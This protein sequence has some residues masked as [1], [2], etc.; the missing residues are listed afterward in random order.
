MYKKNSK[1]S[2][3]K[4]KKILAIYLT[5][6][7]IASGFSIISMN[8]NSETGAPPPGSGNSEGGGPYYSTGD[9]AI[10]NGDDIIRI[11]QTI[12]LK[13][14]LIIE[15]GGKLTFKNVTLIMDCSYDGE[16]RIEVNDGGSFYIQENP[17]PGDLD[18]FCGDE[19]GQ[20]RFYENTGNSQNPSFPQRQNIQ[21]DGGSNINIGDRANIDLADLDDDGDYDLFVGDGDNQGSSILFY[22][23]TGTVSEPIWTN[24]G[25]VQDNTGSNIGVGYTAAPCF[26]DLDDDGDLDLVIGS[27]ENQLNYYENTGTPSIPEWTSRGRLKDDGGSD[28]DVGRANKLDFADYWDDDGDLD[29]AVGEEG[30]GINFYRN[31]GDKGSAIWKL[32]DEELYNHGGRSAPEFADLNDDGLLDLIIGESEGSLNYHENKGTKALP[33]YSTNEANYLGIDS[34]DRSQPRF[35]DIDKDWKESSPSIITANN[36]EYEFKFLVNEGATFVMKNSELSECGYESGE[37]GRAGLIIK[38]NNTLIENSSFYNNYKGIYLNSSHYS[39]IINNNIYSNTDGIY[40]WTS[41]NNQVINNNVSYNR[42]G[43]YLVS[44]SKNQILNNSISNNKYGIN[45]FSSINNNQITNNSV[46]NNEHGVY[47]VFSTNNQIINNSVSNNIWG[48]MF[49]ESNNNQFINSTIFDSSAHDIR[50]ESKSHITVINTTFDRDKVRFDDEDSELI[51]KWYLSINVIDNN[52]FGVENANIQIK[53]QFSDEKHN[54]TTNKDGWKK[55]IEIEEYREKNAGRTE[56][57][58]FNFTVS[59]RTTSVNKEISFSPPD[60]HN[61][62]LTFKLPIVGEQFGFSTSN[63]GDINNDGYDDIIVGA[64]YSDWNGY[65]SG[66]AYVYYGYSNFDSSNLN[67][68]DAN[69]TIVGEEGSLFG[70]S[71]SGDGDVNNDTFDDVIV[72]APEATIEGGMG[73]TYVFYGGDSINKTV[74]AIESNVR[75]FG[76]NTDSGFGKN[77]ASVGDVNGDGFDDFII[78]EF[79]MDKAQLVYG[80]K[81]LADDIIFYANLWDDDPDEIVDFTNITWDDLQTGDTW[82]IDGDDDGWDTSPTGIYGGS[83]TAVRYNPSKEE[84]MHEVNHSL[85]NVS[86]LQIEIGG[87]KDEGNRASGAY[88]IEIEITQGMYDT[89]ELATLKFDWTLFSNRYENEEMLWLKARFGNSTGM[90]YLGSNLDDNEDSDNDIF[91]FV[92]PGTNQRHTRKG[93]FEEDISYL[94]TEPGN[95]YLELGGKN[96]AWSQPD[97]Y[98]IVGYDNISLSLLKYGSPRSNLTGDNI[99]DNFGFSVSSAGDV[100]NDTF[101]DFII[102]APDFED[103]G[104]LY[105][106]YGNNNMSKNIDANL[107]I[108]GEL[109]SHF[110]Y[111]VSSAGDINNDGFDDIIVG[112][113]G[114]GKS[115]VYYGYEGGIDYGVVSLD[116]T[117]EFGTGSADNV[118][119]GSGEIKLGISG[120]IVP[121]GFFDDGWEY[122]TFTGDAERHDTSDPNG[123]I[124]EAIG[125]WKVGPISGGPTAGFGSDMD[126]I[127]GNDERDSDGKLRSDT[128]AI[129]NDV[130]YLH[131]WYHWKVDDYDLYGGNTDGCHLRIF[132]ATNDDE[133]LIIAQHETTDVRQ[134]WE[135]EEELITDVSTLHGY[136]VYIELELRCDNSNRDKGLAQIDDI[137]SCDSEGNPQDPNLFGN[138]TSLITDTEGDIIG[139][140]PSWDASLNDGNI[141]I[142]FRA[143]SSV[144]WDDAKIANNNELLSFN[145]PGNETQFNAFFSTPDNSTT[146]ILRK[147]SY[148]YFGNRLATIIEGNPDDKF[149]YSVS[150]AGDLNNDKIDDII[151]GA[152][153]N[154]E[155]GMDAGAAYTFYGNENLENEIDANRAFGMYYGE[156]END[157]F[158]HSVSYTGNNNDLTYKQAVV[159]APDFENE[160]GWVYL[161]GIKTIDVGVMAIDTP[162]RDELLWLGNEIDIIATIANFGTTLQN[163]IEVHL[164][165][166][167]IEDSGNNHAQIINIAVLNVGQFKQRTFKWT[168]P[169][170]YE[171]ENNNYLISVYTYLAS[172]MLEENNEKVVPT[173]ARGHKVMLECE[174]SYK[175]VRASESIDYIIK[176]TNTGNLGDDTIDLSAIIPIDWSSGFFYESNEIT[177]IDLVEGEY[178]EIKFSV[179]TIEEAQHG[180]EYTIDVSGLSKNG[181]TFNTIE[182]TTRIKQ[183]DLEPVDL[184]FFRLDGV[185]IGIDK[186]AIADQDTTINATIKNNGDTYAT[187][188]TVT[189]YHSG[190]SPENIIGT[191]IVEII[192]NGTAEE[193][194]AEINWNTTI[195]DYTVFVEVDSND[196]FLESNEANND[197]SELLSVYSTIPS[198][199]YIRWIK[200]QYK[201]SNAVVNGL[202]AIKNMNSGEMQTN[203]TNDIGKTQFIFADYS[204]GDHLQIVVTNPEI[205]N[206]N[207][208]EGTFFAIEN[209]YAYSVDSSDLDS[210]FVKLQLEKNG[211]LVKTILDE[212]IIGRDSYA[213]F[214]V[215]IKVPSYYAEGEEEVTIGL[216][217][218][219]EN[220]ETILKGDELFSQ[221]D[222]YKLEVDETEWREIDLFVYPPENPQK[223]EYDANIKFSA[224]PDSIPLPGWY[225]DE[226]SPYSLTLSTKLSMYN[227]SMEIIDGI[228]E[229]TVDPGEST[230][231]SID[232]KNR[233][234]VWDVVSLAFNGENINWVSLSKSNLTLNP[235]NSE[236]IY[237]T[238]DVPEDAKDTEKSVI[239]LWAISKDGTRSEQIIL[240]TNVYEKKHNVE[241][242][243]EY[244]ESDGI[245]TDYFLKIINTGDLNEKVFLEAVTTKNWEIEFNNTFIQLEVG[246]TAYVQ[247]TLTRLEEE[248]GSADDAY[249]LANYGDGNISKLI[250]NK[251]PNARIVLKYN[252]PV[253]NQITVKSTVTTDGTFS[254]D[255][256]KSE[257]KYTWDFGDGTIKEGQPTHMYE[258]ADNYFITLTVEDI[259]GLK[260]IAVR[261]VIVVNYY[262]PTINVIWTQDESVNLE[263]EEIIII[264]TNETLV[265]DASGSYDE[266]GFIE[267]YSWN[268]GNEIIRE[269][270]IIYWNYTN[271]GNYTITL[272]LE[273][274]FGKKKELPIYIDVRQKP[275][276]KVIPPPTEKEDVDETIIILMLIIV[277]ILA[278]L[279]VIA[280][281]RVKKVSSE[282][283]EVNINAVPP[284]QPI[285]KPPS[286]PVTPFLEPQREKTDSTGIGIE[287]ELEKG[288]EPQK[289]FFTSRETQ[290]EI[291][292]TSEPLMEEKE[293]HEIP[294]TKEG[295]IPG[296]QPFEEVPIEEKP[297]METEEIPTFKAL[298]VEEKPVVEE[299]EIWK[300][301]SEEKWT[302]PKP[303]F[304][305]KEE[306][307]PIFETKKVEEK[308]MFEEWK[309]EEKPETEE[310]LKEPGIKEEIKEEEKGTEE[311]VQKKEKKKAFDEDFWS[312][313]EKDTDF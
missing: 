247:T 245:R 241:S 166:T 208:P 114:V 80:N 13:G 224:L 94:I 130:D 92:P 254:D 58:P 65:N 95:Y 285:I 48:I 32:E 36:T 164:E 274:N 71:V 33:D 29:M 106:Y 51:V 8:V 195:G 271:P 221:N 124:D 119:I 63:A 24:Q 86:E 137:Y 173:K 159:G 237:I 23:N 66:A 83:E 47:L 242:N 272:I 202:V 168:V 299:K 28:I 298:P 141:E 235:S 126:T 186:H 219:P 209:I 122:W 165:I 88:G 37:D 283:K 228:D 96:T 102:G 105:V 152:P 226:Y 55:W 217:D 214:D 116:S 111:S 125:D 100:N 34:G 115:L 179:Q 38:A 167:C 215:F 212:A 76:R 73:G 64:P 54:L 280:L 284:S 253:P 72:G 44:S 251:P 305:E 231:F 243:L 45:V 309:V 67:P 218:I 240:K 151:I 101:N 60:N 7:M 300:P 89:M 244:T 276:D 149:G 197:Y 10:E 176:I 313:W 211:V 162:L 257:L 282:I 301:S 234:N 185:E 6:L 184:R 290:E 216:E 153:Y 170:G 117:Q 267:K 292:Q 4:L 138:Y 296:V 15:N 53:D 14:N 291:A 177:E 49:Y 93:T 225:L 175:S 148:Q 52:G 155:K 157:H 103:N 308:P 16:Y 286:E 281:I 17:Q 46:S 255:E 295:S 196:A 128:F 307:K 260:D 269:G 133:L 187:F 12:Y 204:E 109:N 279:I 287:E 3:R 118:S 312:D 123:M 288:F 18:L 248:W 75:F 246:Q 169:D 233:G 178:K 268:L 142:K 289:D 85:S 79:N 81:K 277:I 78:G 25:R 189:F 30:G 1:K 201:D 227:I 121:N 192:Y 163:N 156:N 74:Y 43:I 264:E 135:D 304:E 203:V 144:S 273:D 154:D 232:V 259:E 293:Q 5:G 132:D 193:A 9:W 99:G 303:L 91:Y 222:I 229:K 112:A 182:I 172:D 50:F 40:L 160:K 90:T 129:P 120:T 56:Y 27:W 107:T 181:I 136:T 310:I 158:G 262:S 220:W 210:D 97:E 84:S 188:V 62:V 171:N 57:S 258:L 252:N 2:N 70:W 140:I 265:L 278:I 207:I 61:Q 143:N 223:G 134:D 261:E 19:G 110:G 104:K 206:E 147:I 145:T 108:T 199:P 250:L 263:D 230:T 174:E 194:Y 42:N 238:I 180:Y 302:P 306:V 127:S 275:G 249:V 256:E 213:K 21:D 198:N 26:A 205:T 59:R 20:I 113:P 183:T 39:Q 139:V 311:G 236:I 22:R 146:P 41:T 35:V 98:L 200:V 77:V 87:G 294:I 150:Y 68:D 31:T 270:E 131:V 11:D 191:D 266:D 82:G 69:V 297:L 239:Y 161:V 190:I